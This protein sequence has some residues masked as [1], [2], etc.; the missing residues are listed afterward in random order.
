MY[1][2][3]SFS[4]WSSTVP[5]SLCVHR[6]LR[7]VLMKGQIARLGFTRK[8]LSPSA[9]CEN[10]K[11]LASTHSSSPDCTPTSIQ[12]VDAGLHYDLAL[13]FQST[14]AAYNSSSSKSWPESRYANR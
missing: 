2:E 1:W 7:P 3:K 12:P 13:Y 4:R 8:S 10:S 11:P 14:A 9:F 5:V 6:D